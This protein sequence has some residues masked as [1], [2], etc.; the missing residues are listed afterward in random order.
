M[1]FDPLKDILFILHYTYILHIIFAINKKRKKN[2]NT[3]LR[4]KEEE[5]KKD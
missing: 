1:L 3:L 2:L 5:E 4:E